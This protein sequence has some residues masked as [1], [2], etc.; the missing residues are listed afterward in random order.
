MTVQRVGGGIKSDCGDGIRG[1]GGWCSG[2]LHLQWAMTRVSGGVGGGVG[3]VV[4][5]FIGVQIGRDVGE[6]AQPGGLGVID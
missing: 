4:G 1:R 6:I 5:V 3:D 2:G